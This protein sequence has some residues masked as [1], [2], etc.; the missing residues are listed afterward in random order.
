MMAEVFI[1]YKNRFCFPDEISGMGKD[2]TLADFSSLLDFLIANREKTCL[3]TGNE[4]L[5]HPQLD[6]LLA[7][8]HKK[9]IFIVLET[10]SLPDK[11]LKELMVKYKSALRWKIYHPSNY[12]EGEWDKLLK[13]FSAITYENTLSVELS[14]I[15][16]NLSLDYSFF[17]P[18][19]QK[20]SFEGIHIGILPKAFKG[21]LRATT[22]ES[23]GLTTQ[24]VQIAEKFSRRGIRVTLGCTIPPCLFSYAEFGFL[25][26]VGVLPYKCLPFP[27]FLSDLRVYHCRA[28]IEEAERDMST[29]KDFSEIMNYFYDRYVKIQQECYFFE[30][31]KQCLSRRVGVCLGACLAL[32]RAKMF[33]VRGV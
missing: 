8:A 9:R 19:F 18:I 4:P 15:I 20:Y 33:D 13:N 22:E 25:A 27:G 32:K 28:L 31:C 24:L 6:E 5:L 14:F 26:R 7:I 23:E 21:K 3:L 16:H 17:L 12:P 29:F 1:T 30:D 11:K 10:S 2:I